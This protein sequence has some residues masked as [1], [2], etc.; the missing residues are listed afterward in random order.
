MELM[1]IEDLRNEYVICRTLGHSW[2]ELPNA[3][4]SPELVRTSAA[5]LALRCTRCLTERYDYINKSMDV[6]SRRYVYP[7]HYTTIP[8]EGSRPN[9]RGE[10][11]KRSLLLVQLHQRRNGKR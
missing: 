7:P 10:L 9:L 2:D 5:A 3:E 6:E 1:R 8:G 11:I 4:F